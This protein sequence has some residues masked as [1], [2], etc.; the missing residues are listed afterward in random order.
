MQLQISLLLCFF[1]IHPNEKSKKKN[2]K[3][4]HLTEIQF[5]EQMLC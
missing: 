2:L 4:K 1:I 5:C 3:V